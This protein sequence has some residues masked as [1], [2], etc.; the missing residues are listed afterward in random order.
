M[1]SLYFSFHNSKNFT[2]DVQCLACLFNWVHVVVC[3]SEVAVAESFHTHLSEVLR[4]D[5]ICYCVG[6][7]VYYVCVLLVPKFSTLG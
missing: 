3:V 6:M 4:R 1:P 7:S 2:I 5:S